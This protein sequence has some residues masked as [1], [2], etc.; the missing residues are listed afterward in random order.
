MIPLQLTVLTQVSNYFYSRLHASTTD[1]YK[2][3][4]CQ[5]KQMFIYIEELGDN[6]PCYP[7]YLNTSRVAI[8]NIICNLHCA[9]IKHIRKHPQSAALSTIESRYQGHV[10]NF[11]TALRM[12]LIRNHPQLPALYR[13]TLPG[14]CF[15]ISSNAH[16][17]GPPWYQ[18]V[19]VYQ[20]I[21]YTLWELRTHA[22]HSR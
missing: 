16:D 10:T 17:I 21:L 7:S 14:P 15:H 1:F 22:F 11:I 20:Y 13:V 8:T 6:K 2:D 4:T 12:P 5:N 9:C 19:L 18:H 3:K